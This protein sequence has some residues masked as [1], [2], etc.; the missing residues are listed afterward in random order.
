MPDDSALLAVLESLRERGALGESS[1]PQA[2]R[3]AE[4]FVA[5]LPPSTRRILDLGSGGG[6]PGLVIAS[7]L[8]DVEVVLTDRRERR[9]DLLLMAVSRLSM[10][11][12][13][14]VV[15]ADVTTLA[16]RRDYASSFDAVTARAFGDPQWTLTCAVPFLATDGVIVISDPPNVAVSVRWPAAMLSTL[17]LIRSGSDL[18]AVS[19][20]ERVGEG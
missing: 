4:A 14:E 9:T 1:L 10:G 5:A 2:V 6:L 16:R 11:D 12:R 7:R 8:P 20:F 15:N 3:H 18:G 19:R 13:V 17:G